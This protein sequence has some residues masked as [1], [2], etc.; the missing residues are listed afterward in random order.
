MAGLLILSIETSTGCGSVALTKGDRSDGKV[1]AEFTL[2][3]DITHSRRLLGTIDAMLH[4]VGVSYGD[5]QGLAVSQG[6]GSFTGLRIGMAAAQGLAMGTALPLIGVPTLDALAG[7]LAMLTREQICVVLDARKGQV[8][9]AFYQA[10]VAGLQ[11]SSEYLVLDPEA[12]SLRITTPTLLTGP[13][14]TA[15]GTWLADHPYARVFQSCLLHPR[16]A[17]VGFAA[18]ELFQQRSSFSLPTPLYVRASEAEL[19]LQRKSKESAHDQP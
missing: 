19:N 5:I 10:S 8:Y 14:I 2:Q 3:P 4:A 17:S 12:L 6:P 15:C 18:V 1:L 13:G 16:A 9:T 7:Q 11:R